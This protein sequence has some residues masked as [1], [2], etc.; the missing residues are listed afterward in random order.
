MRVDL[1][2]A[3]N[4]IGGRCLS[5]AIPGISAPAELGAMRY[6]QR[7][8]LFHDLIQ[9]LSSQEVSLAPIA[10]SEGMANESYFLRGW[11]MDQDTLQKGKCRGCSTPYPF[12][13]EKDDLPHPKS[14]DQK[15]LP[16][17]LVIHAINKAWH[18]MT[19]PERAP[20][21]LSQYTKRRGSCKL[22]DLTLPEWEWVKRNGQIS[23]IDL[24]DIGF[25]N[26]LQHYLSNEAFDL[27]HQGLGY[28]SI[29]SNWNAAEAMSWFF[30]DFADKSDYFMLPSGF[31]A[32]PRTLLRT[33]SPEYEA[34]FVHPNNKLVAIR[35]V[36][37]NGETI[38]QLRFELS[39]TTKNQKVRKAHRAVE[40]R[41]LVLAIPRAELEALRFEDKVENYQWDSLKNPEYF[42]AVR[43]H[44]LFK[45]LLLYRRTWWNDRDLPAGDSGRVC[46]DLPL[47][48]MY[49]FDPGWLKNHSTPRRKSDISYDFRSPKHGDASRLSLVMASY[50]DDY[51]VSFWD[52]LTTGDPLRVHDSDAEDIFNASAVE[53]L[54]LLTDHFGAPERMVKKVED[55]LAEV[56]GRK[57]GIG[58]T[59]ILSLYR[60]WRA[61]WHT[62]EPRTR[63][64]TTAESMIQPFADSNLYICGE[65]YS[66]EQ[67]WIEGALKT[68]ERV[69]QRLQCGRPEWFRGNEEFFQDYISF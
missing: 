51:H 40:A 67:G 10:M 32:V 4:R 61:G 20:G 64:W 11:A 12:R 68:S 54:H 62:W 45:I 30:H 57:G 2:E 27:L 47:R 60:D 21:R 63:P 8:R 33:I 18:D 49:Y 43:P 65:A 23:D 28:V 52:P 50:S 41:H 35:R 53:K 6:T 24:C 15:P 34:T 9:Y 59:P 39:I 31:Q 55:L 58:S 37:K 26:L 44:R 38:W 48:Q 5:V 22:S 14:D 42:E 17:D 1:F 7:H 13:L 3:T 16:S 56:H 66:R 69:L 29:V 25:W 46:T 36:P 19:F